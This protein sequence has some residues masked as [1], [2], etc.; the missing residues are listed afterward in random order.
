[1][2]F[3]VSTYLRGRL[4]SRTGSH[5]PSV[6]ERNSFISSI[7]AAGDCATADGC[8][9]ATHVRHVTTRKNLTQHLGE[10]LYAIVFLVQMQ[11]ANEW[12]ELLT[13]R[14]EVMRARATIGTLRRCDKNS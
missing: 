5:V 3:I 4:A 11:I 12:A 7:G 14:E 8:I 6:A 9:N 10:R 13:F 2:N 1:M